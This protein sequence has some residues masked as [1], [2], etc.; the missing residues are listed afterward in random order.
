LAKQA[1]EK[2][3]IIQK[4]PQEIQDFANMFVLMQIERHDADY[5]PD[6]RFYK[7]ATLANI[8]ASEV[9]MT[10]FVATSTKDR[11]AFAAWVLF[12]QRK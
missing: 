3:Q 12:R 9:V 5:D 7:S 10:D 2:K 4:F 8:S 6:K 11:R 1:C